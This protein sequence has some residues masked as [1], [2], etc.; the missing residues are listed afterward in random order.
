MSD[1]EHHTVLAS[2]L[3][4]GSFSHGTTALDIIVPVYKQGSVIL[5]L[6]S[7]Q[8]LTQ[9]ARPLEQLQDAAEVKDSYQW[10]CYLKKYKT[11]P[12]QTTWEIVEYDAKNPEIDNFQAPFKFIPSRSRA[13]IMTTP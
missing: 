5:K 10:L 8:G 2:D 7:E 12:L 11:Q 13:L 4:R 9:S 1:S 3:T 6:S